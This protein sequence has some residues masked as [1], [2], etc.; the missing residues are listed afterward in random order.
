VALVTGWCLDPIA[1]PRPRVG[2]IVAPAA[3]GLALSAKMLGQAS[4][5]R[6]LSAG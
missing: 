2:R 6:R 1:A 5:A 3:A 4:H